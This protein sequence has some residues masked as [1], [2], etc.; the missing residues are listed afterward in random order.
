MQSDITMTKEAL[1]EEI[2][3]IYAEI[4]R[5]F[6]EEH[7]KEARPIA[8]YADSFVKLKPL[9]VELDRIESE[10]LSVQGLRK[11]PNCHVKITI[12]SKFCNMCG[13][14][15]ETETVSNV[16]EEAPKQRLCK[17]CGVVLEDDAV[18]CAN[19]GTRQ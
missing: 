8:K 18:F 13:V 2:N 17:K 6:Y 1:Q 12:E 19:C 16:V 10:E 15:L 14:R 11:C 4:G 7:K 9:Y 3:L 5:I